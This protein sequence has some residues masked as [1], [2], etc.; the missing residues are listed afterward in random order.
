MNQPV[1]KNAGDYL[2]FRDGDSG[3]EVVLV[4]LACGDELP[5]GAVRVTVSDCVVGCSRICTHMGCFLVPDSGGV[6][7]P[8]PSPDGVLRC[9]C[10]SS[11]FDLKNKGLV[12]GGP[13]TEWLPI[14]EL[15][16]VLIEGSDEVT[17]IVP[18]GWRRW[19]SV[20]RGV[21]YG[22]TDANPNGV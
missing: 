22:G 12:V 2:T 20:G 11:C 1:P 14:L 9:P 3:A 17:E 5:P 4:R 7:R 19:G 18:L 10:H 13:A 16:P 6:P 15:R 8:A 21:P